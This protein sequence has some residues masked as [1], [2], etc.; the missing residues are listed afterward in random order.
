MR[1]S[2]GRDDLQFQAS[3]A[4][5]RHASLKHSSGGGPQG[6]QVHH[7]KGISSEGRPLPILKGYWHS[8]AHDADCHGK[9]AKKSDQSLHCDSVSV[10]VIEMHAGYSVEKNSQ[11][12]VCRQSL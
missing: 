10:S 2:N 7:Q 11:I 6:K 3:K 8:G 5:E 12:V 4:R 1:E 9:E